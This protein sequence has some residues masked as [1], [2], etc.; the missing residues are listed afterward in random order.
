MKRETFDATIPVDVGGCLVR[1]PV[2]VL[3]EW[4]PRDPDAGIPYGGWVPVEI[5]GIDVTS[6]DDLGELNITTALMA[7]IGTEP[8][9][10]L[11]LVNDSE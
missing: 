7:A 5:V 9:V 4:Q 8:P 6:A 2:Q 10:D 3:C 1:L 11:E